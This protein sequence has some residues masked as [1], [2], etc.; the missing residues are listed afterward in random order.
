MTSVTVSPAD[1][2]GFPSAPVPDAAWFAQCRE[3]LVNRIQ[4]IGQLLPL[5]SQ[6]SHRVAK[7]DHVHAAAIPSLLQDLSSPSGDH[8]HS[9]ETSAA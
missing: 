6:Q 4:L 9:P 7:I 1:P 2:S 8:A 5:G 3:R